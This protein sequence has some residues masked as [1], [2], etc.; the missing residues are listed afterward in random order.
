MSVP[1]SSSSGNVATSKSTSSANASGANA[2]TVILSGD[3]SPSVSFSAPLTIPGGADPA[4]PEC[5]DAVP[6]R[7]KRRPDEPTPQEREEHEMLHE[8]Y[9][10][11]CPEC[12][13]G[14]G[15]SDAHKSDGSGLFPK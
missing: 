2:S 4:L 13:D 11:W 15:K 14:R 9:R 3:T 8:P 1:S 12:V 7:V 6:L 5:E 10:S